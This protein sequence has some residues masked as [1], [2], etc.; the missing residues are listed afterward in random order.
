MFTRADFSVE[1][2]SLFSSSAAFLSKNDFAL[3]CFFSATYNRWVSE[4]DHVHVPNVT[5]MCKSRLKL[6]Q[7]ENYEIF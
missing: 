2:S 1:V 7:N 6:I 4:W 5:V 3:G